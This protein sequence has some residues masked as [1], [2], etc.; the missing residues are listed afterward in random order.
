MIVEAEKSHNLP[1]ASK[2]P[3]KP[4]GIVAVQTQRTEN[5]GSP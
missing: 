5:E 3:M 4:D 2:R 1:C